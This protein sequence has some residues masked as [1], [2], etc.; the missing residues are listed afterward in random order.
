M[1]VRFDRVCVTKDKKVGAHITKHHGTPYL[2][3]TP[4]APYCLALHCA[5]SNKAMLY[6]HEDNNNY[7]AE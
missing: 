3:P 6:H 7:D 2:P 4:T 1:K 5:Q